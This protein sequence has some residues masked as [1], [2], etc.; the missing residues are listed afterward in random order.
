MSYNVADATSII[1]L[2]PSYRD[3]REFAMSHLDLQNGHVDPRYITL[4]S[5]DDIDQRVDSLLLTYPETSPVFFVAPA[6]FGAGVFAALF[7]QRG[8]KFYRHAM[9]NHS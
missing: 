8:H 6:F 3:A 4:T 5:L 1:L 7:V 9:A 2:A